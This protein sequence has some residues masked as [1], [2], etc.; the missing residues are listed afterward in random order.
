MPFLETP[1]GR[2]FYEIKG[3]GQPLVMLRG[4]SFSTRHWLGFDDLM[5][6]QFKVLVLDNRGIGRT[7]AK[8]GWSLTIESMADDLVQVMDH[9]NIEKAAVLGFSLGGMIALALGMRH[10]ERARALITVNTSIA[11]LGMPRLTLGAIWAGVR[12]ARDDKGMLK[13][14]GGLLYEQGTPSLDRKA[15]AKHWL[16]I[17]KEE[18]FPRETS[19]K[20]ALAAMRFRARRQLTQMTV[21]TLLVYGDKDRLVPPLNTLLLHRIIPQAELLKIPNAGHEIMLDAPEELQGAI[22]RFLAHH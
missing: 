7:S 22:T 9:C 6:K 18:G 1:A 17:F 12:H 16:A 10:P 21:P 11:G 20:Q 14:L 8:A 2:I 15:I 5:A 19:L 4:M 13:A 3:D